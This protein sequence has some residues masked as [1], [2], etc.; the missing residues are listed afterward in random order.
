[1]KADCLR[2]LLITP[3]RNEEAFI[4][5]TI[6]CVVCQT[7]RPVRWLIVSDGSTDR[8]DEIVG[9]YAQQHDWIELLRMPERAARDFGGKAVCF[10]TGYAHVENVPHDVVAS[11][12]ADITFE[13]DYF[14]FLLEKFTED[15]KLGIAGAPFSE[16]GRTY[17]YRFSSVE[18]VS[19]ACQLFRREC[20]EAIGGYV[21]SKG[22]GIDVIAVL[23]AR[24]RGWRT[25]TYTEKQ[26]VHGRPMG[27]IN[28]QYKIVA[29]FKLGQ[30]DYWLGFH[31]VWEIF[32]SFYQMIRK[33]YLIG[34]AALFIGY[35]W[36]MLRRLERPVS[37][38]L[39]EFQRHD[40]MN[41]LRKFLGF[42]RGFSPA[43]TNECGKANSFQT[44]TR[45]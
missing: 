29:D 20:F 31:P 27:S 23:S 26:S 19:G 30:K 13:S 38:E 15:P 11:L 24:M 39:I 37:R 14:E 43:Q 34:G 2:Y 3:A 16:D 42:G 44:G 35:F 17:D 36:G 12:D 10:N 21:E 8:T 33:P 6:E 22:G 9:R 32:R 40:Q 7:V 28:H 5:L 25:R 1:M 4:E 41:R 45:R 18:H